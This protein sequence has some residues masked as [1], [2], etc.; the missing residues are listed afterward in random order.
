[1]KKIILLTMLVLLQIY[2]RHKT[3]ARR[4]KKFFKPHKR[5]GTLR[6]KAIWQLSQ[7]GSMTKPILCIWGQ[8]S[9]KSRK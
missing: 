9:V 4:S 1:M 8:L 3:Q 7:N 5:Y 6:S 2:Y